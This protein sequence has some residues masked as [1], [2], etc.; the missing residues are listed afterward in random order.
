MNHSVKLL[1]IVIIL[2]VEVASEDRECDC[3]SISGTASKRNLATGLRF[4]RYWWSYGPV[5]KLL[6]CL[7][8]DVKRRVG[9]GEKEVMPPFGD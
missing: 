4:P 6:R 5:T 3:G 9:C 8:I 2:F 1:I 7:V